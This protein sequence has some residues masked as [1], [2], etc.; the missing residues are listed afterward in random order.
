VA[1]DVWLNAVGEMPYLEI[2]DRMEHVAALEVDD[3]YFD[4]LL[5]YWAR[6]TDSYGRID[7]WDTREFHGDA[8]DALIECLIDANA[9]AAALAEA[10]GVHVSTRMSD[11]PQ[12]IYA[13]LQKNALLKLIERLLGAATRARAAGKQLLFF[14]D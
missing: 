5:R 1:L 3:G 14:G 6:L 10:W 9:D 4:Y 8:L 2:A 12:A 13:V 11:P 7:P